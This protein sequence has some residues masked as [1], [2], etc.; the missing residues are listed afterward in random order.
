ML[1][2]SQIPTKIGLMIGIADDKTLYLLEFLDRK[3]LDK[4][5]EKF[6]Q[7][8]KQPI[9][10][11]INT[12]LSQTKSELNAYFEG[13]LKKFET[14]LKMQGT[15]FQKAAWNALKK[16]PYGETR[17]YQE[18]ANHLEKPTATRAVAN[19]N[20][21]NSIAIMIPCHRIIRSNGDLGGYAGGID[22]KEQLLNHEKNYA[23]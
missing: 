4:K 2:I 7:Q 3:N 5:I 19:A 20:A 23:F 6:K 17:S 16:I 18:Q 13:K 14:P 9:E 21:A 15:A 22:R 8:L 10:A 1:K 11:G 12:I